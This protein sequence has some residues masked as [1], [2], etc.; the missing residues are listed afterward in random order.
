MKWTILFS[1]LSLV[2]FGNAAPVTNPFG[3]AFKCNMTIIVSDIPNGVQNFFF[4]RPAVAD[5]S[6]GGAP[7]IFNVGAYEIQILADA[8]WRG[9]SWW[10]NGE[11]ISE[12]VMATGSLLPKDIVLITYNP[13]NQNE[14][15][16]LNCDPL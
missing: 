5:G 7:V 10:K 2:Q 9:I 8:K 12:T 16:S 11:L 3:D 14:Q 1:L 15:I 13:K 6:H 4:N